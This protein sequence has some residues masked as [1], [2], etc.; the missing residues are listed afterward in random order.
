ML[1]VIFAFPVIKEL[2]LYSTLQKSD[3]LR[4]YDKYKFY[5][6][7]LEFIEGKFVFWILLV[8]DY[9]KDYFHQGEQG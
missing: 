7:C 9:H 2:L 3:T 5:N 8:G 4:I 6:S 1:L